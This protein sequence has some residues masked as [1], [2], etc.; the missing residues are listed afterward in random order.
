MVK[1]FIICL[2]LVIPTAVFAV[3]E[4]DADVNGAID[5][6]KGG[7]NATTAEGARTSLG[8]GTAATQPSTAFEPAITAGSAGYYWN[9]LKQFTLMPTVPANK[10]AIT[11]YWLSSYSNGAFTATQ[12]TFTDL[13]AHPTTVAGYG[14]TDI[15]VAG[16]TSGTYAEGNDTRIVAGATA[17]QPSGNGSSLTGLTESQITSL[18]TDLQAKALLNPPEYSNGTCTTAKTINAANGARQGMTLT[19]ASACA[20]TFIQP[21]S[22]T[23]V[24]GL[25]VIQASTPTGT[26]TGGKWPGGT[27][28][29]ITATASAV[30]FI[31]CYLDGTNAYCAAAQDF[32]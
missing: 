28:A 7:T 21:S 23:M 1:I 13:A 9:G 32:R 2:A 6:A 20:L 26:I 31:S 11:S 29:T 24:I 15:P 10:S 12:P 16:T 18:V 22:G 3:V 14:I 4:L 30:D 27:V 19:A 17:L 5:I 8:L 25:K